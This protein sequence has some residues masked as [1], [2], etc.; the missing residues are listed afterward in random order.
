MIHLG[1]LPAQQEVKLL[2]TMF[3]DVQDAAI[4]RV[5]QFS[6]HLR[7]GFEKRSLSLPW[8]LRGM[9]SWIKGFRHYGHLGKA[10]ETLLLPK[11]EK[12]DEQ[13]AIRV[14]WQEAFSEDMT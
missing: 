8:S 9:K 12:E 3:P 13:D 5:V 6:S 4:E 14:L 1:Y 7:V 11:W 10:F 2:S